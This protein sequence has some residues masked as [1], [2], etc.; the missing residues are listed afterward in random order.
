MAVARIRIEFD[1]D[2]SASF[3]RNVEFTDLSELG[4]KRFVASYIFRR[5]KL[6]PDGDFT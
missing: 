1:S 4:D 5:S 6:S 2:E 3:E